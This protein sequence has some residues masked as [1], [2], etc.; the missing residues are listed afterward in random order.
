MR[1]DPVARI[2]TP[3]VLKVFDAASILL[4]IEPLLILALLVN[5]LNECIMRLHIAH[6]SETLFA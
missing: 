2:D 1:F 5:T 3:S 4:V 6:H